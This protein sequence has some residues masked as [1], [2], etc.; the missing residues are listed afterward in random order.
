MIAIMVWVGA[1]FRESVRRNAGTPFEMASTPVKATAPEENPFRIRNR[2]SV[3]P[4]SR[5][6]SAASGSNG[7]WSMPPNQPRYDLARPREIMRL[8]ITM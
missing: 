7:I 5:A 4:A 1:A 6:A 2:P 8:R 3:P